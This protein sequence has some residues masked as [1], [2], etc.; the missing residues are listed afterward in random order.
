MIAAITR[1]ITRIVPIKPKP[2][3]AS[4]RFTSLV[5]ELVI[6]GSG[7]TKH[8]IRRGVVGAAMGIHPA[9]GGHM[10][11]TSYGTGNRMA[12]VG[13]RV[14]L[15][16]LG[17]AGIVIGAFLKWTADIVGTKLDIRAFWT[18]TLRSTG[19]FVQTAGFAMI[20]L[21][22]VAIIGVAL[23]SGWLTRLAGAVAIVGLILFGIEVYRS[24]ADEGL[25]L[26]AWIVLAGAI[27][28]LV[29]GFFGSPQ[30]VTDPT[31]TQVIV[32]D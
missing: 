13:I 19:T 8:T 24:P 30:R 1:T 10:T 29:A 7:I 32:E 27:V 22:L 2:I 12:G 15:S 21:G 28:T 26:G 25:Q 9:G 23:G 6:P 14:F 3:A 4:I 16:L 20:V 18:T 17:T 31:S 11:T 5:R